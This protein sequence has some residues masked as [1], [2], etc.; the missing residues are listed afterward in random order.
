MLSP[1]E[2]APVTRISKYMELFLCE[3][4]INHGRPVR[5]RGQDPSPWDPWA[6]YGLRRIRNWCSQLQKCAPSGQRTLAPSTA[7]GPKRHLCRQAGWVA[8]SSPKVP[9]ESSFPRPPRFV[10]HPPSPM[11]AVTQGR[12]G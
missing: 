6:C 5:S 2:V 11:E 7:L 8:V 4:E 1:M 10:R 3:K 12:G 9:G